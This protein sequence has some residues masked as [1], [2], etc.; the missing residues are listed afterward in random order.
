MNAGDNGDEDPTPE[1]YNRADAT[2]TPGSPIRIRSLA[3]TTTDVVDALEA[4][5]RRQRRIVLRVT[6][7][8]SGRMRARLHDAGVVEDADAGPS[9]AHDLGSTANHDLGS[10]GDR[11]AE[12]A[13][14]NDAER[15]ADHSEHADATP[16]S[17]PPERFVDGP[18]A[19]PTVD[20]TEDELRVSETTYT[21]DEHRRRHQEAVEAWRE[22]VRDQ[23]VDSITIATET[24]SHTVAVSYLS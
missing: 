14:G 10:I 16:I 2:A 13:A 9:A 8:F 19:Y 5:V 22:T 4:R 23:L 7:P 11:D 18:P 12:Q 24:R 1:E 20:E 3:V 21:R 6:P 17:L 15:T